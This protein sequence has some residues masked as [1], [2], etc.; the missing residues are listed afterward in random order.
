LQNLRPASVLNLDCVHTCE[1]MHPD[2]QKL[3]AVYF[4]VLLTKV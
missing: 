1:R 2:T 4:A 3:Q